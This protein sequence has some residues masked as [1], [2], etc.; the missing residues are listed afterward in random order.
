MR[1]AVYTLTRDRLDYTRH[2]FG[3]LWEKAGYEYDHY[4]IDN[5]S[6]D[7]TVEWLMHNQKRFS[8]IHA[9]GHNHGIAIASNIALGYIRDGNYDLIIKIDNDCEIVTDGII[10]SIVDLYGQKWTQYPYDKRWMLSPFVGGIVNQPGRSQDIW[11]GEH[12]VGVTSQVG[13]L[14]QVV[15]WAV[16]KDYRYPEDLPM[17]RGHDSKFCEWFRRRGGQC[18]YIENL[19]VNHYETTDGQA[20]RYPEYFERKRIEEQTV[21]EGAAS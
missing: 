8:V 13:G 4:V 2:C 17:A 7:E 1:V 3:L 15:P 11:M 5:G 14:F 9:L 19:L 12:K 16:V 18:G 21:Y 10:G 6:Q 20:R